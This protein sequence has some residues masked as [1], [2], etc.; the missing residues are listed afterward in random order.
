MV[1]LT[2]YSRKELQETIV[3]QFSRIIYW[4]HCL[5]FLLSGAWRMKQNLA[6]FT[7]FSGLER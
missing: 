3:A 4:T 1:T 7:F 5:E 2:M 6:P